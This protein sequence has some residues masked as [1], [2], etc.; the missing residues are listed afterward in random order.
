MGLNSGYLL[1]AYLVIL[2]MKSKAPKKVKKEV[3]A[4]DNLLRLGQRI[5]A[6]R[7]QKGYTSY[8]TFAYENDIS[9]AQ[10]GRY[11]K[12][13]DLRFSSLLKVIRAFDMTLEEFFSEGFE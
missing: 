12:G 1:R 10:F 9:R 11:E 8:E 6:L 3:N 5:K 13:E 2:L 4:Q 7:I